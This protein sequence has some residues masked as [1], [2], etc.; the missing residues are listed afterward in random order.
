MTTT[1]MI[2]AITILAI[3]PGKMEV[4]L[5]PISTVFPL[6]DVPFEPDGELP[7]FPEL[8]VFFPIKGLPI[9][10][11]FMESPNFGINP[12]RLLFKTSRT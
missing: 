4:P 5:D 9:V 10:V 3:I 6:G 2:T 1:N 11:S 7:L 8:G 12:V